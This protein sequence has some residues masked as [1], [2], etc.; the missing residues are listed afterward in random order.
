[1]L[2]TRL[3]LIG[4]K[5][6]AQPRVAPNVGSVNAN[7]G[8]TWDGFLSMNALGKVPYIDEMNRK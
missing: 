1:M 4:T 3:N 7:T 5:P 8:F 2:R 6:V